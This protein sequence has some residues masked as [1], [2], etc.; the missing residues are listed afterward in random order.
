MLESWCFLEDVSNCS[1]A[2]RW[3]ARWRRSS[4]LGWWSRR[5][6]VSAIAARWRRRTWRS[7]PSVIAVS[8]RARRC[9]PGVISVSVGSAVRRLAG[10]WRRTS[11]RW[12]VSIGWRCATRGNGC[13]TRGSTRGWLSSARSPCRGSDGSLH[14]GGQ[15]GH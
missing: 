4:G 3:W 9:S 2:L 10:W 1:L 6:Q 5:R 15:H 13:T 8:V 7:G 11:A 14:D 12:V